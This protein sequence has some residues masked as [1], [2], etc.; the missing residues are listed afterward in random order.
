MRANLP[1][2]G[3]RAQ[4]ISPRKPGEVEPSPGDFGSQLV[5]GEQLVKAV[6]LTF[7][8]GDH[9]IPIGIRLLDGLLR[10]TP[11]FR[12]HALGIGVGIV[13]RPLLVLLRP[14]RRRHQGHG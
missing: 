1:R 11:G 13:D 6:G 10:L 7:G 9:L 2:E 3:Y 4:R 14:Q 5:L 8:P 12:D